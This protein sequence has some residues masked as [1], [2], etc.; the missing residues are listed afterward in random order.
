L[1]HEHLMYLVNVIEGPWS[2]LIIIN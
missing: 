1:P 2:L